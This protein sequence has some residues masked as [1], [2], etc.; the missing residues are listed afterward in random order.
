MITIIYKLRAENGISVQW[1]DPVDHLIRFRSISKHCVNFTGVKANGGIEVSPYIP[2]IVGNVRRHRFSEYWDAG[3]ARIW[4][5][6]EVKELA[7][8]IVSI[9]DF[10]KKEEDIPTVW[11]DKDIE[12]DLIDDALI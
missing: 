5:I 7:T 2:L 4:E 11:F 10:R 8:R 3:L 12:L 6:P 9:E 1:G